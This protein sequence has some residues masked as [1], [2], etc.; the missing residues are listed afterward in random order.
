LA[1]LLREEGVNVRSWRPQNAAAAAT[2]LRMSNAAK[3]H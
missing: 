2:W 3:L 1:A